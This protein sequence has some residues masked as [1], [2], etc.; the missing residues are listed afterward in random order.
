MLINSKEQMYTEKL[1]SLL[2]FGSFCTRY[3]DIYDMY[4]HCDKLDQER[5][6]VCLESYIFFD[7]GM[8]ENCISDVVRR[9]RTVFGDRRYR[10][11]VDSSDKRWLDDSIDIVFERILSFLE[12]LEIK[13]R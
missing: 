8:R 7:P 2:K 13:I 1:R 11:R 12:E 5:L 4:Y 3:K 9:V 6:A 10:S